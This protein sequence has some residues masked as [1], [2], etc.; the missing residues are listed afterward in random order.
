MA[1]MA[2]R[3]LMNEFKQLSKE[4]WTNIEVSPS[5]VAPRVTVRVAMQEHQANHV[6][7]H[8]RERFRVECRPN[9]YERRVH[10]LWWLFQGQDDFPSQL[11]A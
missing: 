9:R 3:I 4:K 8:Q 2:Q 7:A 10:V 5:D 6:T 1:E 11:P